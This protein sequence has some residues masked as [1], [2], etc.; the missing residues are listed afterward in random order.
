MKKYFVD[1]NI[2]LRFFDD[3]SKKHQECRQFFKLMEEGQFKGI[4]CSVV[5]LEVY[6]VLRKYYGLP[7]KNCR[8]KIVKTL[9]AKN[10]ATEDSF[11]YQQA[12]DLFCNT[13][14]KLSDC[15]IASLDF[16]KKGGKLVSY[17]KDFDKLG[18]KRIEPN[19][20]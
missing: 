15:L 1:S 20:V 6:F 4:I 17:D 14:I 9:Q 19:K 3:S 12:V 18:V 7:K 10:L 8:Q 16:F 5:L 11:D 2:F 13:G